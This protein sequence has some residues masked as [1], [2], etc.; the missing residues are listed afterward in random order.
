MSS[1]AVSGP[2]AV[3][4]CGQIPTHVDRT[5]LAVVAA[6]YLGVV[7][8][9]RMA[10]TVFTTDNVLGLFL[11]FAAGCCSASSVRWSTRCG[12]ATAA[13]AH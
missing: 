6:A 7:L 8:L 9:F 1:S 11:C 3:P 4:A 5:D 13:C 2:P 12:D 10:F